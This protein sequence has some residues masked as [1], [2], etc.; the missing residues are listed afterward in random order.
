MAMN[1][2]VESRDEKGL[3]VFMLC[4]ICSWGIGHPHPHDVVVVDSSEGTKYGEQSK[5]LDLLGPVT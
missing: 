3:F 2:F 1:L 5:C 4:S